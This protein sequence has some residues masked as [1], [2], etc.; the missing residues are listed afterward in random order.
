M[1]DIHSAMPGPAG[2]LSNLSH[3][4]FIFEGV[5]FGSIEGLLQG[6]RFKD[7]E[8]QFK[9]FAMHGIEAKRT[10]RS[11][12]IKN[13]TMYYKGVPMSRFSD[14]YVGI[15]RDGYN[16]CFAQNE[17]FRKAIYDTR[18][19]E[20]THSIG[21]NNPSDTIWTNDEFLRILYDLKTKYANRL[22]HEF[23]EKHEI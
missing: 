1:I 10:G 21:K 9:V 19:E 14:R 2:V 8:S 6:L 11:E 12:P 3:H 18:N 16:H 7:I 4:P 23:G 20:L 17:V 5:Q 22:T 13:D 15:V